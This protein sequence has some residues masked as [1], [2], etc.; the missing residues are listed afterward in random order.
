MSMLGALAAAIGGGGQAVASQAGGEIDK[1]NRMDLAKMQADIEEQM[2]MRIMDRAE[3]IRQ[4]GALAD[5]SGPLGDAKLAY[6]GREQTQ[7]TEAEVARGKA[8]IPVNVDAQR[9]MIP[10]SVEAAAAKNDGEVKATIANASN[11]EF[12]AANKKIALSDPKV[13]AQI[14]QAR[15]AAA[16]SYASA[17]SSAAHARVYNTQNEGLRLEVA[18]KQALNSIYSKQQAVLDDP[19]LSDVDRQSKLL[20]LEQQAILIQKRAGRG[21]AAT[22]DSELDTTTTEVTKMNPDGGQVKTTTKA[23]RR[24]GNSQGGESP[25]LDGAEV[26]DK[27]GNVYVVRDGVPVP[28]GAA[29]AM[30]KA[31]APTRRDPLTGESLN[32]SEWDRKFGK[33]DFKNLYKP[34]EDSIKP[35]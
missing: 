24:P 19:R 8:M 31:A 22:K 27:A 26:R 16:S 7:A 15:A 20:Q 9:S 32:Q 11:A 33:G 25:Y 17:S 10:V 1:Q 28:K 34:G 3:Q 13:A 2:R 6:K 4:D 35:L 12:L 29:N 23:V 5:V 30:P 18:D 14:E 21:G